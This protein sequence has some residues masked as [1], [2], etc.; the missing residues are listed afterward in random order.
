MKETETIHKIIVSKNQSLM[1]DLEEHKSIIE[2]LKVVNLVLS[3]KQ[4]TKKLNLW[5]LKCK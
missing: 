4:E 5:E 1:L 2:E 3:K